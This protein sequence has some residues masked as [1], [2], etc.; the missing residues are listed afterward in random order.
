MRVYVQQFVVCLR[1][2]R[3]SE[4]K[5]NQ[6]S[7]VNPP[8]PN[9]PSAGLMAPLSPFVQR[10]ASPMTD[11]LSD[12]ALFRPLMLWHQT[13]RKQPLGRQS[14]YTLHCWHSFG[15]MCCCGGWRRGLVPSRQQ[16]VVNCHQLANG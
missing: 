8:P 12:C 11:T 9:S 4:A 2:V 16:L 3:E 7:G 10:W 14:P 15:L 1:C 13:S 5:R 6:I